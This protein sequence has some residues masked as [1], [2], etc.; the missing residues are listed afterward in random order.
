MS[1]D[2]PVI[3]CPFCSEPWDE[4]ME[5]AY[6]GG[7]GGCDTCGYGSEPTSVEIICGKC[8]RLVYKKETAY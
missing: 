2:L 4:D 7:G 5:I 3:L 6:Y 8:K 1:K